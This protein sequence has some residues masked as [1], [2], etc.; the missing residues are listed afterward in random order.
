MTND[1]SPN[2]HE[3]L[4]L[5]KHPTVLTDLSLYPWD[6]QT[7]F[8]SFT[9]MSLI[10]S[11]LKFL[12]LLSP[13]SMM[14]QLKALRLVIFYPTVLPKPFHRTPVLDASSGNTSKTSIELFSE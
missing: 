12:M 10:S 14:F 2:L 5:S 6:G 4:P 9:T 13:I 11:N 1:T 7:P 3:T 8:R